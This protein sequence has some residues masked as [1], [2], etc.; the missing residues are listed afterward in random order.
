MKLSTSIKGILGWSALAL[1]TALAQPPTTT[2]PVIPFAPASVSTIPSNGD[3]NPYGVA[4]APPRFPVANSLNPGDVLVSNFN[5][6]ANLAGLGSTIVRFAPNGTTSTFF[7]GPAGVGLTGALGIVRHGLVFVGNLPSKD[8][9]SATASTGSLL[10]LNRT[11]TIVGT[12]TDP[13]VI[14]G[15]WGMAVNDL[16]NTAQIFISNV[17]N[18]TVMRLD[19]SFFENSDTV[20]VAA[21]TQIGGNFA[22]RL[23]PNAFVLGPS[24]LAYDANNDI[25]Y[26]A[27]SADNAVYAIANAG[28]L[29]SYTATGTMIYQDFKH[30]HGAL[31]LALA[32]NGDLICANSDGSNV[33]MLQPSEIVEFTTKGVFVSQFQIDPEAG[34]AFGVALMNIGGAF[35]FAAVND[36][37]STLTQWTVPIQ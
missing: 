29:Q 8:G 3:L 30:L 33:D 37:Q 22:H 27:S 12:I 20:R 18:G 4:F 36:N 9:T 21:T 17:L 13:T 25:L 7:Q 16:G 15:P 26:V 11:G 5:N 2:T 28:S 24:G 31:G 6:S 23:D 14:N 10:M 32:P 35:R 1:S 19:L 34:G